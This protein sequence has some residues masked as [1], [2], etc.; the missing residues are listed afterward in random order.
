MFLNSAEK[1][2]ELKI[3]GSPFYSMYSLLIKHTHKPSTDHRYILLYL[4]SKIAKKSSGREKRLRKSK[5][6][7]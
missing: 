2:T 4:V 5:P 6:F 3:T 1:L 7:D